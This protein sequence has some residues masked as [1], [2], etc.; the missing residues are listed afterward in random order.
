LAV[1]LV[2]L[3]PDHL[4]GLEDLGQLRV[5][6]GPS[7]TEQVLLLVE[8]GAQLRHLAGERLLPALQVGHLRLSLGDT[9][10]QMNVTAAAREERRTEDCR[11]GDRRQVG[12]KK[13]ARAAHGQASQASSY[14]PAR[15]QAA[16][17]HDLAL[18]RPA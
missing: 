4:H 11:C 16:N 18:F 1:R 5:L 8:L 7:L 3:V 12:R 6:I 15:R 2:E 17:R 10:R 9:L 14:P 13:R